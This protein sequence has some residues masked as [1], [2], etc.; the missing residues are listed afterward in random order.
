MSFRFKLQKILEVKEKEKL[1]AEKEFTQATKQFEEVARQLYELL[2]KK[3]SYESDYFQRIGSK[4]AIF[5]IQQTQLLLTQL[6]NQ[7]DK[8]Q[9]F[10]QRARENM[11]R[12]QEQ[13]LDKTIELK[14]YEKMK[15]IKFD[16]YIEETKRQENILMDEISIQ[17]FS[18]R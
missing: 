16:H 12:K 11:Q 8:L 10:T 5:E 2:K 4:I 18:N 6:Q 13:L 7:I 3:E 17:Q 9:I 1:N 15:Q 14:K